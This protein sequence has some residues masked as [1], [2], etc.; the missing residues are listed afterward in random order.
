MSGTYNK[1]ED[2]RKKVA[3]FSADKEVQ[4]MLL[5]EKMAILDMQMT[6]EEGRQEE[7]IEIQDVYGW[8]FENGRD[9]DV[10]KATKDGAF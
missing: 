10:K 1:D 2:I 7:R 5:E 6:K 8:L 4:A 9:E 3:E